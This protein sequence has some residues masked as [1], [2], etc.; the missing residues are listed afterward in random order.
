MQLALQDEERTGGRFITARAACL[1]LS[2]GKW[3]IYTLPVTRTASCI[4][5]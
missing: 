5:D 1:S 4:F 2:L 3:Q